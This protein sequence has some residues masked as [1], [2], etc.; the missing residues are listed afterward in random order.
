M[1]LVLDRNVVVNVLPNIGCKNMRARLSNV[2]SINAILRFNSE[3]LGR[4]TGFL[5]EV[6]T[7][8]LHGKGEYFG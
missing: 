3:C 8:A 6:R 7:S 5:A 4:T 1:F 2:V